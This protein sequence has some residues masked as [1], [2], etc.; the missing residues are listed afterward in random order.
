VTVCSTDHENIYKSKIRNLK[1]V[2]ARF[3]ELW[4][5]N[6]IVTVCSTDHENIYKSKIRNLKIVEAYFLEL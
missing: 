5:K 1:I 6:V 2:N 4:Y 3:L